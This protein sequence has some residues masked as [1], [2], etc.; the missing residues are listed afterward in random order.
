MAAIPH[1][2]EFLKGVGL[3]TGK[4]ILGDWGRG[5]YFFADN[6]MLVPTARGCD[7]TGEIFFIDEK[8]RCT[9]P[10]LKVVMEQGNLFLR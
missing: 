10:P 5:W 6:K 4:V 3:K 2:G 1:L 9:S 7:G 8:T